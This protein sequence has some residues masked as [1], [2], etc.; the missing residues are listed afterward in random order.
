[1]IRRTR[2]TCSLRR[3]RPR[4]TAAALSLQ[5]L[6]FVI[7]VLLGIAR[8]E[9]L[10]FGS[11]RN[12]FS[13]NKVANGDAVS[14][15]VV[16]GRFATFVSVSHGVVAPSGRYRE[17]QQEQQR[18]RRRRRRLCES[19]QASA[20]GGRRRHSHRGTLVT[21]SAT[22]RDSKTDEEVLHRERTQIPEN[23]RN[24]RV[25]NSGGLL[26]EHHQLT[27]TTIANKRVPAQDITSRG[28]SVEPPPFTV[29]EP[30]GT[31][32]LGFIRQTSSATVV[33]SAMAASSGLFS[34][35]PSRS[36]TA[37]ATAANNAVT[38]RAPG[39][40]VA[41]ATDRLPGSDM[42][43]LDADSGTVV[44][45]LSQVEETYCE[46][47][48]AYLARFLLNYDDDC[49]AYFRH[50]M[51]VAVKKADGRERW[52]EF[53]GFVASVGFGLNRY[54]GPG[55]PQKLCES[56]SRKYASRNPHD[57]ASG[58]LAMLFS[59]LPPD[60]QPVSAITSLLSAPGSSKM[61]NSLRST[62][63]TATSASAVVS[64]VSASMSA[65]GYDLSSILEESPSSLLPTELL[66]QFDKASKTFFVP[67]VKGRQG[68]ML[69]VFGTRGPFPISK[70]RALT[71]AD[72]GLFA[73][74]GAF[75]CTTTHLTV[76]PLD[77]VKTRLQT[78]PGRYE[79]LAEGVSTIAREEGWT[80]LLKGVGPTLAGYLWYGVTV[81][82][83]YELFKRLFIG[84]AGPLNAAVLRVPLVLA[85][86]ATATCFACIGV[87]PAEAVRIRQVADP[88]IGDMPNAV[89]QIVGESGWGKL[90]EGLPSI[91]FRQIS[92]G[93]MKFLVFDFFTE[94][95]YGVLPMLAE[96]TSTQLSVSLTSGLVAGVCA[97][98]VS[99]PADT[100]LSRMNKDPG[101][102]SIPGT[103][104]AIV[105]ER[106]LEG[107]F[108]GLQSRIVWSGAII[109]GQFLLYDICKTAL[110]VGADDLKVFL[111]VVAS[112]DL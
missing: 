33:I 90:Y 12:K 48:V 82:P 38:A 54:Q 56:L 36:T 3:T 104:R 103:L 73:A 31:N 32:R 23:D 34:P 57:G 63:G 43:W 50:K 24:K 80:M 41:T 47:F 105:E 108:L 25:R 19:F 79:G 109:S 62:S 75:G 67:G 17:H 29:R 70:E 87:C 59:L 58:Q 49:K 60:R 110:H 77:V 65:V 15:G 2:S 92:F 106:G 96:Q 68:E 107:L 66:P 40:V 14:G 72:Y 100:V 112:V 16:D 102:A 37:S 71:I 46:G 111:D 81:Y 78:E 10:T 4:W 27:A 45:T 95:A 8:G 13:N 97:A 51:D 5:Y 1:M 30:A 35:L 99:Q 94:F 101:R 93:M 88:M 89:K 6:V 22:R 7:Y 39:G 26:P 52:E 42:V 18:R 55:G 69:L 91:L 20:S 76:V 86:G 53:R 83:G 74:C 61:E 98:I 21:D 85:A 84:L 11:P 28:P 44:S 64:R 9:A